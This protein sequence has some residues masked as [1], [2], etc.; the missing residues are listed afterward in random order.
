MKRYNYLI[1]RKTNERKGEKKRSRINQYPSS[2][3]G[4]DKMNDR[5]SLDFVKGRRLVV[6]PKFVTDFQ[7][8]GVERVGDIT[9]NSVERKPTWDDRRK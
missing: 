6:H 9:R 3:Q 5:P 1:A 2:S 7:E 4:K 8:S